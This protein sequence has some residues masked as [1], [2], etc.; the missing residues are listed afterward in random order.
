VAEM[1]IEPDEIIFSI[2]IK[3]DNKNELADNEKEII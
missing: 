2:G 3:A 1:E